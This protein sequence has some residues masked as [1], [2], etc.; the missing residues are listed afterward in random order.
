MLNG[1]LTNAIGF[2]MVCCM[3]TPKFPMYQDVC[4]CMASKNSIWDTGW[5]FGTMEFYDFPFS[6]ECHNPN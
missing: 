6:W 5:W 4:W 1:I 2:V 3:L